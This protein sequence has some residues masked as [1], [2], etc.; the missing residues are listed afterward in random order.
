M[1]CLSK[2]CY[3]R[4]QEWYS[5]NTSWSSVPFELN[6][7]KSKEIKV[8][9]LQTERCFFLRSGAKQMYFVFRPF[10][11][12]VIFERDCNFCE[13]ALVSW[14]QQWHSWTCGG[15]RIKKELDGEPLVSAQTFCAFVW[16]KHI[17]F[18]DRLWLFLLLNNWLK[19][20]HREQFF[21]AVLIG[22][23]PVIQK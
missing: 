16:V 6:A 22:Q 21:F 18:S 7:F 14:S 8:N 5:Y 4:T 19:K 15:A 10:W 12:K 2:V 13:N 1:V 3:L 23:L 20:I 9:L 11:D 17:A